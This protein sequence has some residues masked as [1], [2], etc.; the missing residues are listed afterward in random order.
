[1][2][3]QVEPNSSGFGAR[4]TGVDLSRPLDGDVVAAIRRAWLA[5]QVV[6]FPD[7]PMSHEDLERFTGYLG[8]FGHDPYVAPVPGHPHVLEVRR[9]PNE[10]VPPF[11]AAW[12]VSA[13]N[14][15][16]PRP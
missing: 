13:L 1:M 4:I 8:E 15:V 3:I 5:H 7:Q 2:S 16:A 9:N 14:T 6:Y 12:P 11:G 10:P